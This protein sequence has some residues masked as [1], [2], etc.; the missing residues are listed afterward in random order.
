M[1]YEG[2]ATDKVKETDRQKQGQERG[3]RERKYG[4][5]QTDLLKQGL[6]GTQTRTWTWTWTQRKMGTWTWTQ[7]RRQARTWPWLC[8]VAHLVVCE[9]PWDCCSVSAL[10]NPPLSMELLHLHHHSWYRPLHLSPLT[11]TFPPLLASPT[12]PPSSL[13]H[14]RLRGPGASA[15]LLNRGHCTFRDGGQGPG[16]P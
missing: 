10:T 13:L 14:R 11:C 16:K 7:T 3:Q 12:A 4:D 2:T 1:G 9:R 15:R 8:P 5:K 6:T